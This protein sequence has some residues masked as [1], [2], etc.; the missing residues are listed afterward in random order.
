MEARRRATLSGRPLSQGEVTGI[1]QGVAENASADAA[2]AS[3]LAQSQTQI[4]NQASQAASNLAEQKAESERTAQ[5]Q[6]QQIDQQNQQA[7]AALAEQRR[8]ADIQ[9]QQFEQSQRQQAK[10]QQAQTM[11]S[12]IGAGAA[13]GTYIYPGVGTVIGAGIGA[14]VGGVTNSSHLCTESLKVL[15]NEGCR[16]RVGIFD[17]F[18]S[19]IRAEFPQSLA[20]YLSHGDDII[21]GIRNVHCRSPEYSAWWRGFDSQIIQ[22]MINANDPTP[23]FYAYINHVRLV[24]IPTYAPHLEQRANDIWERELMAKDSERKEVA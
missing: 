24:V 6:Q 12:M 13:I 10:Q 18:R 17:R 11:G 21:Q 20:F 7:A 15:G 19:W 16:V 2:R 1:T 8:E 5:L 14:I 23:F 4:E 9:N 3:A 22:P